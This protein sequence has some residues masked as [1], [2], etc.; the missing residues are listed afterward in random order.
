MSKRKIVYTLS[1]AIIIAVTIQIYWLAGL[2]LGIGIIWL[3]LSSKLGFIL[4]LKNSIWLGSFLSLFAIFIVAI[5]F[6]IFFIEIFTIPSGSMEDTLLPGDKVLVTKL[7]YGP[8][9]PYSPY[10]IPWLNLFWYLQA[11][12]STNTDTIFWHYT[13]LKGFSKVKSGDVVV[14]GHPLWGKRDNFFVKRCIGLPG[15]TLE[16]RNGIVNIN[17]KVFSEP[18]YVKNQYK[19]W[20]N[21]YTV[22]SKLADRFNLNITGFYG[23]NDKRELELAMNSLNKEQL[24]KHACIDSIRIKSVENDS[25][26][27]VWV[28]P[29]TEKLVWTIDN[30][31]PLVIPAKGMTINLTQTNFLVYQ[32][33]INRLE[34][35]RIEEKNGIFYLNEKPASTYTFKQNYYFMMGDNRG[36]SM[37]S[38]YW[39]F[40]PEENIVGKANVILL[41]YGWSGFRWNRVLKPIH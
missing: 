24:I 39:G 37:D 22:L 16:I 11:K 4:W 21:N 19:V 31:G 8:R 18:E 30:F 40:V 41:S 32:Q 3:L 5:S 10:E 27:W 25:S 6:R 33:S 15:D 17:R 14:F 20:Y 28:Y 13:R 26:K 35:E 29:K 2:L 34:K 1:P 36:N 38:R 23:Q 12:A 7:N 9:M